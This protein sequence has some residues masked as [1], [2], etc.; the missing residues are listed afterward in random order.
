MLRMLGTG[1][2]VASGS[3]ALFARREPNHAKLV[4][5]SGSTIRAL[6]PFDSASTST[7]ARF[8]SLKFR[9]WGVVPSGKHAS[10]ISYG[11]CRSEVQVESR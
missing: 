3:V 1:R 11:Y 9:E 7:L 2:I 10:I 8:E 5:L 6:W 4:Q